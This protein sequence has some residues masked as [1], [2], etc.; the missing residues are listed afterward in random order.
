MT[1]LVCII[2]L[3]ILNHFTR[4]LAHDCIFSPNGLTIQ[5]TLHNSTSDS[6]VPGLRS[7]LIWKVELKILDYFACVLAYDL[8]YFDLVY[9]NCANVPN[10]L[11]QVE[12][13]SWRLTATS[14]VSLSLIWD[15]W[16]HNPSKCPNYPKIAKTLVSHDIWVWKKAI[17][18]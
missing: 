9:P 17:W 3:E 18:T 6:L 11:K 4:V 14:S 7:H 1:C 2:E 10:A 5:S 13:W 12:M 15:I 8:G 16:V